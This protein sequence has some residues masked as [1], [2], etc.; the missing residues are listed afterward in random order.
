M[1]TSLC[2]MLS[3]GLGPLGG[4]WYAFYELGDLNN[5]PFLQIGFYA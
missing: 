3:C 5:Q 2:Y 1:S 4:V